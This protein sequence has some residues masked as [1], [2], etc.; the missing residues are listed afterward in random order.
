MYVGG[1]RRHAISEVSRL[2]LEEQLLLDPNVV[3]MMRLAKSEASTRIQLCESS[4]SYTARCTL[5]G[6]K[7]IIL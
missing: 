7:V 1:S 5:T 2:L 4:S 6:R 3:R